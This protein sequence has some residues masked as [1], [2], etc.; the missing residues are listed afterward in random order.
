[1]TGLALAI[2]KQQHLLACCLNAA[3]NILQP[4]NVLAAV[5]RRAARRSTQDMPSA[6]YAPREPNPPPR[7]AFDTSAPAVYGESDAVRACRLK[8]HVQ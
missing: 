5:T 8:R 1:M 4:D 3:V 2:V 7:S 6:Q